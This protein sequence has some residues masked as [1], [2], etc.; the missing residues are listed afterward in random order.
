MKTWSVYRHLAADGRLLYVGST[1]NLVARTGQHA[2]TAPWFD[3]VAVVETIAQ[4]ALKATALSFEYQQIMKLGPE[5][6]Q[7]G[8]MGDIPEKVQAE[9]KFWFARAEKAALRREAATLARAVR[10]V[11]VQRIVLVRP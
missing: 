9:A 1:H 3:Q 8:Q 2:T 4:F 10:P 5:H 6:N 7:V 11:G